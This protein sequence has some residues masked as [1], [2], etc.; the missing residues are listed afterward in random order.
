MTSIV[1]K[2]DD[3]LVINKPVG[4]LSQADNSGDKDAVTE[5]AELLRNRGERDELHIINRLDRVVGGLILLARSSRT[6]A[7]LSELLSEKITKEYRAVVEDECTEG[8]MRD[9]LYKD[10]TLGR[11]L[12]VNKSRNGAKEAILNYSALETVVYKGRKLSLVKVKLHTG[13]FHQIRAQF[14]S[15]KMP[16]VGDKKYGSKVSGTPHPALFATRL[17]FSYKGK[18]Y[19]IKANPDITVFPWSLFDKKNFEVES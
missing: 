10:A 13:R 18:E 14:S 9:Y 11:A 12:V 8:E 5:C 7:E 2:N 4:T 17:A 15:R 16:L 19:D 3:F 1:Y 6:A